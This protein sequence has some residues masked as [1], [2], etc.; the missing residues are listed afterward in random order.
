VSN[1]H[2]IEYLP[3][4]SIKPDP[5][6]PRTH[7][8]KQVQQIA[9]SIG[10]SGYFNPILIEEDDVIICG[11][12]RYRAAKLQGRETVPVI[13]LSGLTSAAKRV[14]R[15]ADNKIAMN[16]GWDIDLLRV[17]LDE[18]QAEGL[19]LELTGFAMGEI[20]T[21]LTPAADPDDEI[22]PAVP[23]QPVTRPGDIWICG[24]H[25]IGS[26]DLLDGCSLAALMA[27]ERADAIVS[28]PP[29][30]VEIN[31]FANAKGRHR[32]FQMA[33]GEMSPEEFLEFIRKFIRV[34]I[35]Y[36]RDGAVHLV[37]MDWRHIAELIS[38]GRALYGAFLN[39]CVWNK[40]NAGMGSLYRSKHE[41]IAVFRA[42]DTP[43]FNA[44][45]LGR[46]G[47]NRTNVFDYASVNSFVGS[48]RDDLALHPTVKPTALVA[49]AIQDVTRRGE[50]VLDPFLGSGTL[51]I[52]CELTGRRARGLE[53]EPSYVDVALGRWIAMTGQQPVLEATGETFVKRQRALADASG[54][55]VADVE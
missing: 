11:H 54:E 32:E 16:A 48:R 21:M 45:E 52:A 34:F 26:G 47:R 49:D 38:I 35:A 23:E 29:Y 8:K 31:G 37:F 4:G 19:N 39:L 36:S 46:H 14:L 10:S 53:I 51:L 27:D 15:I 41:L 30:N 33:S 9:D 50:I 12:G 13:R 24:P 44:V 5:K 18:I 7:S 42:G 55:E 1:V 40:S 25:R 43:H 2:T 17:E 3:L 6:N 22:I 20:D 28:D